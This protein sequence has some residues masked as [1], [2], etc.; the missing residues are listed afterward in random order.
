MINGLKVLAVIPAR[1]GSKGLPNKNIK[2][3]L[4]LPLIAYSINEALKSNYLDEVFVSTDCPEIA[5]TAENYGIR[6]PFLRPQELAQD[7]STSMDVILHVIQYY[8]NQ[9]NVFDIVMMLEPT[10]PLR[11]VSDIDNSIE[12]LIHSK[13]AESVVG[14]CDVEAHHPDF[15]VRIEND[16]LRP[17][18]NNDFIVKR[19]QELDELFFFEGTVYV[20]Y[21]ESIKRRKNFYHSNTI[22][23]IVPKWKS[24]EVDSLVDFI[25]IEAILEAKKNNLLI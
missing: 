15:L 14:V 7:N 23:Y 16:F 24:F 1:G 4:G 19:R 5:R 10:S 8:E 6:I 13:R 21:V 11:E 17:Y 2:P 3:L 25:V 12:L 22:G 20:S 9:G 18:V